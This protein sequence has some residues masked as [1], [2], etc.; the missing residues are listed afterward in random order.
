MTQSTGRKSKWQRLVAVALVGLAILTVN[1][2]THQATASE[3]KQVPRTVNNVDVKAYQAIKDFTTG[4]REGTVASSA[5]LTLDSSALLTGT[6]TTGRYN[7]GAYLYGQ[8]TSAE[9]PVNFT[10]SI[11][12]M[13]ANTAP[14]TWTEVEL[15]A[16]VDGVW[17][18]WYSMGVWLQQD[19]PFKRH[20][21]NGQGDL[22]GTVATDTLVLKKSATAV[23]ARVTLFTTD[24]TNTPT[25]RS[26][27]LTFSNGMDTAGTVPSAGLVSDLN[28]PKRSQMVFPNGGEVWCSPT[29]TSM[30][31]AYWATVT[32]NAALNQTV[33]TVV[34][35]VW[36]YT[37]NGGGNW[38]YNTNYAASF[39][40]QAKVA[41][42]SSLAEI[43]Q[44]TKAGVP[45]IVS[46]AYKKGQM[47]NTPIPSTSGHLLV[48]RGFD[49]AGNVLTNDPAAA[50]DAQVGITYNR[51]QF[52]HAWLDKAN[53]TTYLM[54]PQ[55]WAVPATNGH[56]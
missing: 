35:G 11:V 53:G 14:G 27:G 31:M 16:L 12:S 21:V 56:W 39:D 28:V 18:K 37:Y 25:L 32:G 46:V 3:G 42:M 9:I 55:G 36:D 48:V 22:V 6:D 45:V 40:L 4:T 13:E 38:P 8:F 41:R 19:L 20:S 30:V 43:E 5:G 1:G 54:Y 17:S 15:S 10:E 44:W 29:S 33:P 52:E 47:D 51:L 23:K 7:S 2:T 24:P 26:L 49:A 34:N 50:S